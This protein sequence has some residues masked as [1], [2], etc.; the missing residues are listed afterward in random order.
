MLNTSVW[1]SMKE[2]NEVLVECLAPCLAHGI[3]VME[4]L[5]IVASAT[6]AVSP[7]PEQRLGT[8]VSGYP[9]KTTL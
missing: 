8:R 4:S 1:Q 3:L 2:S 5:G 7:P 9:G 6:I